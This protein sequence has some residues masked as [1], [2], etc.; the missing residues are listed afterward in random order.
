[1]HFADCHHLP[2]NSEEEGTLVY[3]AEVNRKYRTAHFTYMTMERVHG[4]PRQSFRF[5]D[6][7]THSCGGYSQTM[8]AT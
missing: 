7:I 3:K 2:Q 1:M 4:V 6:T 5:S 8:C